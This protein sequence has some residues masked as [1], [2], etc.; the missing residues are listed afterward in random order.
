MNKT[1]RQIKEQTKENIPE[2]FWKY[3]KLYQDNQLNIAEFA[4]I[5]GCARSTIYK[6]INLVN[7]NPM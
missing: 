5:M 2:K 3:Y 4:R 6:Y 1:E 7:S